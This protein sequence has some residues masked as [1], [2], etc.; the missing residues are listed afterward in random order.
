LT[1]LKQARAF[2]I[3]IVLA[4]QNTV[5]LD[6][7]GLGNAG[8]WFFGRLQTDPDKARILDGPEGAAAA[9]ID[10]ET[11]DRTLS[12]LGKR[13]FLLHDVHAGAPRTLMTR[14]A[15]SD[16]RRPPPRHQPRALPRP[17]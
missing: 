1:L 9:S 17:R 14:R 8:T 13:V 2:G 15:L 12:A 7:K 5:D 4:T 10:R 6:Y 16:L 11:A 3:G